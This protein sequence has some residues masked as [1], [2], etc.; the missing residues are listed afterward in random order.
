[1]HTYIHTA[2]MHV[3]MYVCM[4]ACMHACMHVLARAATCGAEEAAA[5]ED[6]RADAAPRSLVH[7]RA[8]SNM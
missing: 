2:C 3:R 8:S 1:M 4:H 7:V 5:A 6:G